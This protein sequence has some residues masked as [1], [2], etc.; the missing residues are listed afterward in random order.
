MET[1]QILTCPICKRLQII[2]DQEKVVAGDP[3]ADTLAMVYLRS[4]SGAVIAS[5][6]LWCAVDTGMLDS[7]G[8]NP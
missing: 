8:K 6:T 7:S 3:G 2:L 5:A 4:T 1:T